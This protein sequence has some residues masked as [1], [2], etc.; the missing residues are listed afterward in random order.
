MYMVHIVYKTI[1]LINNKYYIGIHSTLNINDN[2]LGCGHWRGRKVSLKATSSPILNAFLKYG[3]INFK[4]EILFIYKTREEALVKEQEL[5]NVS[6][7][8]CYN[9]RTGGI[10]N[11]IYTEQAKHKM[12][13]SA[14]KRS[15]HILLQT[16]IL[17]EYNKWRT[18]KTYK[19]IYGEEKGKEVS[20]KKSKAL[21]GRKLS[22]KHKQK[23]S[24]N[25]K[26]KDC[27]KCKNR[28]QVWN[29]L[30]N[31]CIRLLKE[32]LQHEQQKGNIINQVYI[33]DK[34]HK[35]NYIKIN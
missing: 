13:K 21:T 23:M 27:G 6:D 31:K 32:D 10:N 28:I 7:K 34:F 14:K 26:G 20:T 29:S 17:K 15:K 8:M 22:E 18:G 24:E 16:I 5:I 25:R 3:D 19:E 11:Y 1:N 12:S 30:T 4:K 9:A 2:Y 33:K 35:F